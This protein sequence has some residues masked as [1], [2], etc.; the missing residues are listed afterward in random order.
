[1]AVVPKIG[2]GIFLAITGFCVSDFVCVWRAC[3][4]VSVLECVCNHHKI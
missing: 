3:V 2:I 4:I 1:M